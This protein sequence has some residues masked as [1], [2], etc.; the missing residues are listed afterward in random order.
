MPKRIIAFELSRAQANPILLV[1]Y[2]LLAVYVT[3]SLVYIK[4]GAPNIRDAVENV[5]NAAAGRRAEEVDQILGWLGTDPALEAL[6][7][8]APPLP[9]LFFAITMTLVPWFVMLI[10][11]DQLA[12]DIRH[13]HVRYVLPRVSRGDLFRARM[14]AGW[15]LWLPVVALLV[16]PAWVVLG[17]LEPSGTALADAA[18][19][20][21]M[22]LVLALYG[23]PFVALI[24]FCNTFIPIAF[25]S[26]LAAIGVLLVV[27]AVSTAGSWV[28]PGFAYV[29]YLVPTSVKYPLLS[30][31]LT[32][33]LGGAGGVVAYTAVFSF[34]GAWIFKR[35]DL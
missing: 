28:D 1:G 14:L 6:L 27:A 4:R 7:L 34:L 22:A 9:A 29:A 2:A 3:I 17:V 24:V 23:A 20:A 10:A 21:R 18:I 25:L 11:A 16:V 8:Q 12:G 13:K 31:E 19:A 33:W 15:L 5:R 30:T 32:R 35:R 26:Y